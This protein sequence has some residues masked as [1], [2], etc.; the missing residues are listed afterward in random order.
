MRYLERAAIAISK[1]CALLL[2]SCLIVSQVSAIPFSLADD[3]ISLEGPN[4]LWIETYNYS[5]K[6][7]VVKLSRTDVGYIIG[8]TCTNNEDDGLIV[9]VDTEG[10]VLFRTYLGGERLDEIESVIQCQNGDF[11]AVGR[12]DSYSANYSSTGYLWLVRL[13]NNGSILWENWYQDL[14]WGRSVAECQ[15]G[16]IIVAGVDPHLVHL[17][18]NG[19]VI[20]SKSYEDWDL[21]SAEGVVECDNGGFAFTGWA[22]TDQTGDYD[23]RAWLVCTD[24]N[25]TLL[26]NH[27]Y[28]EAPFNAGR[29]LIQCSDDGFAIVGRTGSRLYFP[30]SLWLVRTDENGALL[31]NTTYSNGKGESVVQCADGGFGIAGTATESGSYSSWDALF[32]RTDEDGNE[33]WRSICSG[34]NEDRGHSLVLTDSG[35]FVVAGWSILDYSVC[36]FVW[37]LSDAYVTPT[38]TTTDDTE[39]F[40]IILA[41]SVITG[42]FIAAVIIFNL[43]RNPPL[44][45]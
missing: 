43:R 26:W 36:A 32:I 39:L 23:Y 20:W 35:Q 18:S 21:S 34:P 12:T 16:D 29:S 10:D 28:G 8:G 6:S 37:Q 44:P 38:P 3:D 4:N 22:D 7:T 9:H 17:D 15:D 31:W 33:Q 41:G 27:T 45:E 5:Y 30:Q 19:S 2:V 40:G 1:V 13:S 42:I 14:F 24:S 11:I 25:G